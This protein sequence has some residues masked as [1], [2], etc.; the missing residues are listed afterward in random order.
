MPPILFLWYFILYR[1]LKIGAK[2]ITCC[3]KWLISW[4]WQSRS[5]NLSICDSKCKSSWICKLHFNI[6]AIM[7]GTQVPLHSTFPFGIKWKIPV[8]SVF[9]RLSWKMN[10][11]IYTCEHVSGYS[12]ELLCDVHSSV[13]FNRQIR[14]QMNFWFFFLKIMKKT[15]SKF[16][17]AWIPSLSLVFIQALQFICTH[18]ISLCS[19]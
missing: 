8:N 17:T 10:S 16:K 6:A 12:C 3:Y 7:Y 11:L 13:F 4:S 9:A 15:I 18:W 5:D 19:S 14:M 2:N 1:K